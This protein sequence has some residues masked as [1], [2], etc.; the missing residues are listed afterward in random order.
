MAIYSKSLGKLTYDDR[1][2][3]Y[4]KGLGELTYDDRVAHYYNTLGLGNVTG[5]ALNKAKSRKAND[6]RKKTTGKSNFKEDTGKAYMTY[7]YRRVTHSSWKM[8]RGSSSWSAQVTVRGN[9]E[10]R[11]IYGKARKYAATAA[12]DVDLLI[13]KYNLDIQKNFT[14]K[15]QFEAALREEMKEKV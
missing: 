5:S 1:V 6:T 4:N 8:E 13:D 15:S 3:N 2:T 11:K 7:Q 9:T 12:W 10:S 14:S